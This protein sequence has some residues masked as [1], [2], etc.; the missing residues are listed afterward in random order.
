PLQQ[1]VSREFGGLA[2]PVRNVHPRRRGA[3]CRSRQQEERQEP[4]I[5]MFHNLS[6]SRPTDRHSGPLAGRL[7]ARRAASST[8]L[9]RAR[10][11]LTLI[12][13][14]F[15]PVISARVVMEQ[16]STSFQSS[17][18]RSSSGDQR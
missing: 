13:L 11:S 14:S 6:S 1:E 10:N 8:S 5:L 4:C 3:G 16:P 15:I 2:G 9:R 18:S 12:V 17:R 7:A